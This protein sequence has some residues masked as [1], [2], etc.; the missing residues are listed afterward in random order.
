MPGYCLKWLILM[1]KG[2]GEVEIWKYNLHIN[3]NTLCFESPGQTMLVSAHCSPGALEIL[4]KLICI[5]YHNIFKASSLYNP[6][7]AFLIAVP[8]SGFCLCLSHTADRYRKWRVRRQRVTTWQ[9]A[10]QS[11]KSGGR[12]IHQSN[13]WGAPELRCHCNRLSVKEC[14]SQ[15]SEL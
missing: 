11:V 13:V 3:A 14:L 12:C 7:W 9:M 6:D 15:T 10:C 5:L 1:H 8:Y 4:H 2:Q